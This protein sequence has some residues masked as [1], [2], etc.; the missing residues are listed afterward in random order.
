MKADFLSEKGRD[1]IQLFLEAFLQ[2]NF[3]KEEVAREKEHLL[4]GNRREEDHLAGLAFKCFLKT[5]YPKHPY[6]LP[7]LGEAKTVRRLAPQDL[8][9]SYRA[10]FNP[11]QT[12]VSLVGDFDT[13]AMIRFIRPSLEK[14]RAT[15]RTVGKLRMDPPPTGIQRIETQKDKF[16]AHLVLGFRGCSFA[17]KDR[18]A[19][20]VLNNIL[21]GQGG[22]LF[23]ELR[24]KLSL[25]YSVTSVSQEG[26]EPGYFGVYIATEPR[27]V[28]TAID[29]ILEE[30]K[31]VVAKPVSK[32]ELD[33]AKQYMVGAYEID[34]QRNGMVAGQL[35]FNELYG[36]SRR[37]WKDLSK[38][39]LKITQND[40]L[41]VARRIIQLDRYI[42]SI[43]RP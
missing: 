38:K 21:A 17:D 12:V 28:P 41:R 7:M 4:E 26:I 11:K 36:L 14:I 32:A 18:Y 16:Q 35:A 6:G 30:L 25:A 8:E 43:V 24:D 34:L 19:L 39:I 22:R 40:V 31:K 23:L 33:R 42:L 27:K 3:S 9:Q 20:D 5:L 1:G 15:V 2:P 13:G 29:G 37:E 10:L